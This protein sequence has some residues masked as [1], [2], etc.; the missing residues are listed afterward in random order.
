[1]FQSSYYHF[2]VKTAKKYLRSY[3]SLKAKENNKEAQNLKVN[4]TPDLVKSS[5]HATLANA[6]AV[7][8]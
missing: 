2:K 3:F 1:M 5:E 7:N 4:S 8:K 6:E